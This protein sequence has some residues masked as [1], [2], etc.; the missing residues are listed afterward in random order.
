MTRVL[1]LAAVLVAV[2][3]GGE[4]IGTPP[5]AL[6]AQCLEAMSERCA[7]EAETL[8]QPSETLVNA[9]ARVFLFHDGS[10]A[11]G[12]CMTFAPPRPTGDTEFSWIDEPQ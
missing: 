5:D 6:T 4:G 12:C 3:C 7:S 1:L 11:C 8:I 10:T 9:Y 2:G